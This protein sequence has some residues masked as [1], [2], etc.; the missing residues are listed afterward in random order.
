MEDV[1]AAGGV[2]R[3]ILYRHFDSKG[4]L[5]DA[6]LEQVSQR[7]AEAF[8]ERIRPGTLAIGAATATLSVA[9]SAG[10]PRRRW[11]PTSSRAFWPGSRRGTRRSTNGSSR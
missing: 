2:T 4:A 1:A 11:S 6:V 10:G 5:Y 7:L 3:L 9:R 8:T